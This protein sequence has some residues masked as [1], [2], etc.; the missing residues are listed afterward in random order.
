MSALRHALQEKIGEEGLR[1]IAFGKMVN[2]AMPLMFPT[3]YTMSS[4][5]L[6]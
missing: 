3:S 1:V 5:V 6:P 2:E 4:A